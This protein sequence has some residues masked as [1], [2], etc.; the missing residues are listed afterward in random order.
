M[1]KPF[2]ILTVWLAIVIF[3]SPG[4]SFASV[5]TLFEHHSEM[6]ISCCSVENS[7]ESD[8]NCCHENETSGDK[9]CGDHS[10]PTH[11]CHLHS[12][13]VFHIYFPN[14]NFENETKFVSLEKLKS[15]NYHSLIIKDLSFSF[16]NPPKYIA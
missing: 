9:D 10:C 11:D 15:D 2:Q 5:F 12:V 3:L 4:L 8:H 1:K 6:E 7:S 14:N 13:N 16:W